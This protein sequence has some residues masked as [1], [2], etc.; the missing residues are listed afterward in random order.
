[1]NIDIKKFYKF[2]FLSENRASRNE[3]IVSPNI[4]FLEQLLNVTFEKQ[5]RAKTAF[6]KIWKSILKCVILTSAK[7]HNIKE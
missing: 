7:P 4:T 1:M 3:T 5:I 6:N 2:Y